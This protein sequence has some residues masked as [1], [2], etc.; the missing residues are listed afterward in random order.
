MLFFTGDGSQ[1]RPDGGCGGDY[2]KG[3]APGDD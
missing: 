1:G 3:E 2:V